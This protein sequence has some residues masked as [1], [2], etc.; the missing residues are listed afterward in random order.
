MECSEERLMRVSNL[1]FSY[2]G[3]NNIIHE[4]DLSI[5]QGKITVLMGANGCGKSTLFQL[6]TKN[7]IPDQGAVLLGEND[8]EDMKRREFAK[9]VAIVHQNNTAPADLTVSK[10]VGYGRTPYLNAFQTAGTSEDEDIIRWAMEVTDL[11]PIRNQ[12]VS[13]LSGGQRQRVWIAMALA[14]K[15]EILFLDEPTTY[16]DIRY[17]IEIMKLVRRLNEEYGI[18]IIMVLHDIN[19]AMEYGDIFVG[20]K[21]GRIVAEGDPK[22]II[23]SE[24]LYE[25]YGIRLPIAEVANRKFVLTV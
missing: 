19:Q 4:L 17:Q 22:E 14:Q 6:M 13:Q 5:Q 25:L 1:T 18:T 11:W 15:T 12:C 23:D 9:H 10:L 8:I 2:D 24:I 16:L 20:M 3:G 7:L 21:Q